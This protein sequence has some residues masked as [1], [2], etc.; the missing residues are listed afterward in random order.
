M[1]YRWTKTDTG[2]ALTLWPH[3]S[4]PIRGFAVVFG[5]IFILAIIPL[6]G[7]IGTSL[8]W[9]MLPFV[10]VTLTGLYFAFMHTY[11][12]GDA[13]EVLT[14]GPEETTLTHIPHKGAPLDWS[15]NTYWTRA[16]I[17]PRQGP[18]PHYITLKGNGREVELGKFL[19]EDERKALIGE[20]TDALKK[21]Q[22]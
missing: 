11:R 2:Q 16:H 18:V 4:L 12:T 14:I 10:L 19:S 9:G 20:L 1:P 21:A 6:F 15:C 5:C 17:Y 22:A 7:L 8:L 13:R 3:R